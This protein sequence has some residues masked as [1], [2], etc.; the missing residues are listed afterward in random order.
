MKKFLFIVFIIPLFFSCIKDKPQ[1][2]I[3]PQVQ[4][5]TAKKVYIINEGNFGSGN[6]SVS[7]YDTGNDALIEN[8][9]QTQNTILPT[10]GDVAQSLS[11]INDKFYLVVNNSGKI[12]VC[13]NQFKKITQITNLSS[14]RYLLPVTNQKAYVSDY[15]ANAISIIDLNSNLKTGSIP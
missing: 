10:L 13:D 8:F 3:Q 1:D 4:L 15:N 7:L 11:F 6:A 12:S 5:S 9:Y 2:S 14:P